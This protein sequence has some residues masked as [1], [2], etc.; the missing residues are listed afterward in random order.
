[1]HSLGVSV[2]VSRNNKLAVLVLQ[3]DAEVGQDAQ[4]EAIQSN[5]MLQL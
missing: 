4:V 3:E 1:M 2:E 5:R